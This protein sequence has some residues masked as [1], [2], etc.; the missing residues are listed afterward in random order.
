VIEAPPVPERPFWRRNLVVLWIA[1][2]GALF[3]FAVSTPFVP[4][5]LHADLGVKNSHDLAL[6]SGAIAAA[7]AFGMGLASPVW[8]LLADRFGRKP[9][10]VRSIIGGGVTVALMSFARSPL[11]LLLL[12]LVQGVLS[13]TVPASNALVAAETPRVQV[14]W[15]LGV[16]SSSFAIGNS[17][18][19]VAG[20]L[21]SHAFG[22]RA[23][24]FLGGCLLLVSAVPVVA[25]VRE[26]ARAR[27]VDGGLPSPRAVLAAAGRRHVRALVVIAAAS[28]MLA[29]INSALGQLVVLRL[30]EVAA[31]R[32]QAE[33]GIAFAAAGAG[34]VISA[35]TIARLARR[36][37][38]LRSAILLAV[39]CAVVLIGFAAVRSD[40]LVIVAF[41]LMSLL[42]TG[43]SVSLSTMLGLEAP[44][45]IQS[46]I[47]G[48]SGSVT[49]FGF[50]A[51]PIAGGLIASLNGVQ[52]SLAAAAAVAGALGVLLLVGGREPVV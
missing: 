9:M 3:G 20:G 18:G 22:L 43:I 34:S 19:P 4:L 48:V 25:L 11:E 33:T 13:G 30:I 2:F 16:L 15:A 37:G 31:D 14:G 5:L 29:S 12:R 7:A 23:M 27:G 10:L 8:G 49:S 47:Y 6:W 39:L 28:F 32:A 1:E 50:A 21:G 24:F 45:E 41:A 46:F 26:T 44:R 36:A 40:L 51:G 38:Y 52:F 17:I 35:L 42:M